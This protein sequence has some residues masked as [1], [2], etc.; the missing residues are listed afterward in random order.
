MFFNQNKATVDNLKKLA[1]QHGKML[2]HQNPKQ[3]INHLVK[4]KTDNVTLAQENARL[5]TELAR[6]TKAVQ[7]LEAKLAGDKE[8][9]RSFLHPF[10]GG[11]T[12][13]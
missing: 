4:L 7:R 8:N 1:E 10:G 2:G 6:Q 9:G 13:K 3:K 11:K 5:Q 12:A